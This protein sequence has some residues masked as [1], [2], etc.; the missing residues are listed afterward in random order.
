[1]KLFDS[2]QRRA[3]IHLHLELVGSAALSQLFQLMQLDGQPFVCD[4][5]P[6]IPPP[7]QA[8]LPPV[9]WVFGSAGLCCCARSGQT[10]LPETQAPVFHCSA[11]QHVQQVQEPNACM[12]WTAAG[13]NL[14]EVI[15]M[16]P[17][18]PCTCYTNT[19]CPQAPWMLPAIELATLLVIL[20]LLVLPYQLPGPYVYD[21]H[22]SLEDVVV[23]C[24]LRAA[25]ICGTYAY[26]TSRYNLV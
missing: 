13:D 7:E 21:Y 2:S 8:R 25:A 3:V 20:L 16:L 26:G 15:H 6:N 17:C 19:C 22:S 1:M 9:I 23:L 12:I 11:C 18:P 14:C 10:W 4:V 5:M 24:G